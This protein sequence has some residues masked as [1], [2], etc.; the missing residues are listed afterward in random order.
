MVKTEMYPI[1]KKMT[2]DE[3]VTL[4]KLHHRILRWIF[5]AD[6]FKSLHHLQK[7]IIRQRLDREIHGWE[8]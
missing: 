1:E 8:F 3:Q 6:D 5:S 2:M 4:E 7:S